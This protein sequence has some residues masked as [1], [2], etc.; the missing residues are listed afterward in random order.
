VVAALPV[1]GLRL[2]PERAARAARPDSVPALAGTVSPPVEVEAPAPV[3]AARRRR[4][5]PRRAM[6]KTWRNRLA[7]WPPSPFGRR[8]L[9]PPPRREAG[10]IADPRQIALPLCNRRTD[11]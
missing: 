8:G 4:S 3:E 7:P 5:R 9:P 10:P 6:P 11:S 2:L 1:A